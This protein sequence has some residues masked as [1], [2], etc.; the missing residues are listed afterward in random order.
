MQWVSFLDPA[1]A[2]ESHYGVDQTHTKFITFFVIAIF[3]ILIIEPEGIEIYTYVTMTCLLI[4]GKFGSPGFSYVGKN[5]TI[6]FSNRG[7]PFHDIPKFKLKEL[8][9]FTGNVAYAFEI[10]SAYLSCTVC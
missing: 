10:S 1:S 3:L 5:L 6:Y 7:V 8:G 2:V 9:E 4:L